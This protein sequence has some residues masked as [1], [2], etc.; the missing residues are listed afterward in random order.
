[1]KK[2]LIAHLAQSTTIPVV[3]N[4]ERY[5]PIFKKFKHFIVFRKIPK[6][7]VLK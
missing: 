1:M 2:A 7:C 6:L 5:F 3:K 4:H